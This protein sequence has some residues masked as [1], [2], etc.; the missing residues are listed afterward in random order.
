MVCPGRC[1]DQMLCTSGGVA[2]ACAPGR[3][4]V[5]CP[6]CWAGVPTLTC[7]GR[8]LLCRADG[9]AELGQAA[10]AVQSPW[11][12][13]YRR[14][15]ILGAGV[16]AA[17][18]LC[19][20]GLVALHRPAVEALSEPSG[21]LGEFSLGSVVNQ[22]R[23]GRGRAEESQP[24]QMKY[25]YINARTPRYDTYLNSQANYLRHQQDLGLSP[26]LNRAR[27]SQSDMSSLVNYYA[28]RSP[29]VNPAAYAVRL[30]AA[31]RVRL[32]WNPE[33]AA[34]LLLLSCAAIPHD[35]QTETGP[36]EL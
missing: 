6:V 10:G 1:C 13:T 30:C 27:Q 35:V 19:T 16:A 25:G 31:V 2:Q 12:S 9:A 26:A 15:L 14:R 34:D 21:T 20:A 36:F 24:A 28:A 32:H 4:L 29:A 23:P 22:M 5:L 17:V 11:N 8:A 33:S 18:V 7:R 3:A